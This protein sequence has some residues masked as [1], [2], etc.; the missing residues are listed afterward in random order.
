M[1]ELL[2]NKPLMLGVILFL[3]A[4]K[5]AVA[6]LLEWQESKVASIAKLQERLLKTERLLLNQDKMLSTIGTIEQE[7]IEYDALLFTTSDDEV[8]FRLGHQEAIEELFVKHGLSVSRT[9]W[10]TPVQKS[11]YEEQMMEM[12]V[13]GSF[14]QLMKGL[15]VAE[16]LKP[17]VAL[18]NYTLNV[19]RMRASSMRLG[20]VS[21]KITFAVWRKY[22]EEN[23]SE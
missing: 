18:A 4:I 20:R 2:N 19:S 8:Q 17:K 11:G 16:S 10:L 22:K 15:L 12:T 13:T 3:A 1:R 6:P 23:T 5:F 7:V 14:K 21:G 9:S